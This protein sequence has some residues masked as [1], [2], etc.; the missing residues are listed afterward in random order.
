MKAT[1]SSIAAILSAAITYCMATGCTSVVEWTNLFSVVNNSDKPIFVEITA[2]SAMGKQYSIDK[3]ILLYPDEWWRH[4][5]YWT[6]YYPDELFWFPKIKF[7]IKACNE[8]MTCNNDSI[9]ENIELNN[10]QFFHIHR[11][12]YYPISDQDRS[13]FEQYKDSIE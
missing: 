10:E 11:C 7:V 1:C 2:Y 12:L 9:I 13:I 8:D 6:Y 4:Y 3:T 5:D